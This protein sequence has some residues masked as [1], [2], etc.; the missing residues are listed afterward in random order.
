MIAYRGYIIITGENKQQHFNLLHALFTRLSDAYIWLEKKCQFSLLQITYLEH[1]VK[2]NNTR[3]SPIKIKEIVDSWAPKYA[4]QLQFFLGKVYYYEN[5][6][7][8]VLNCRFSLRINLKKLKVRLGATHLF[9]FELLKWSL[10]LD[11]VFAHF[12][13][14]NL[15]MFQPMFLHMAAEQS[16]LT[17]RKT[18]LTLKLISFLEF[19]LMQRRTTLRSQK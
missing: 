9:S 4:Q 11:Q 18:D 12:Y 5:Y 2:K 19:S 14:T 3:L 15:L 16:S 13:S 8:N 7:E 10:K 6:K 1:V 17:F